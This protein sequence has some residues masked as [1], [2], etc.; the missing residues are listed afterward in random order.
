MR[1]HIPFPAYRC[2]YGTLPAV[3]AILRV[4]SRGRKQKG[5][6]LT[7]LLF[8]PVQSCHL[9]LLISGAQRIVSKG[10]RLEVYMQ[11]QG[12]VIVESI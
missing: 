7:P 11:M 6:D 1:L 10:A 12:T 2:D 4:V 3:D 9:I 5:E 8:P